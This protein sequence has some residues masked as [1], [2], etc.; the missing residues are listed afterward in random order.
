LQVRNA[1]GTGVAFQALS[2]RLRD[3]HMERFVTR[4]LGWAGHAN[5]VR[6]VASEALARFTN[7]NTIVPFSTFEDQQG[8]CGK[9]PSAQYLV[10]HPP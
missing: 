1:L 4:Q 7:S 9:V 3:L 8:Y 2:T 10:S 5:A 6:A